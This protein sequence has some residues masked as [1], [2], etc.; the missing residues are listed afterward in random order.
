MAA[1]VPSEAAVVTWAIV[2]WINWRA[3]GVIVSVTAIGG[4]VVTMAVAE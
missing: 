2:N 1:V 3:M 4:A